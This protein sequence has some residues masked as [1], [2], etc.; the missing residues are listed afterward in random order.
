MKCCFCNNTEETLDHLL[1]CQQ[2]RLLNKMKLKIVEKFMG[3]LRKI[4]LN[5]T[6][7]VDATSTLLEHL[8]DATSLR[9]LA[10][11]LFPTDFW[12][13]INKPKQV[14]EVDKLIIKICKYTCNQIRT[15]I[16]LEQNNI[17]L[18]CKKK[19]GISQKIKH[20]KLT[21]RFN[22]HNNTLHKL[23]IHK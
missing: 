21:R 10:I 7:V 5:N 6:K 3:K 13:I 1:I 4:N 22:S 17:A 23:L 2:N 8:S 11:G 19:M 15:N 9:L 14:N 18:D 12:E 16:W 20:Q